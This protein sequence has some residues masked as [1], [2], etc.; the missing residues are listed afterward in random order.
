M[1]IANKDASSTETDLRAA[2]TPVIE[3]TE[4]C[5]Y[6]ASG[7]QQVR[8]VEQASTSLKRGEYVA[9]TGPSGSGKSTLMNVLGCLD[10]A[11]SGHYRIDGREVSQLS[12]DQRAYIRNHKIGFIF[13]SFNLLPRMTALQN[14]A[15]PL[16]YQMIKKPQRREMAS[17]ALKR[18]GLGDRLDHR[19]NALSGGQRQRVAIARALVTRP[20][21]L[22]ADEPTGNLDSR[23]GGEI[24]ALFDELHDSGQTIIM[25]THDAAVAAR[26]QRILRITDGRLHEVQPAD[27]KKAN[28]SS[29]A[30]NSSSQEH[31]NVKSAVNGHQAQTPDWQV[32]HG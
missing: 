18:V 24:L 30:F 20:Q 31:C 9:L 7:E 6:Y 2:S 21:I 14:V 3:L 25:V 10:T 27:N 8:A 26:C 19:P 12:E 16:I 32:C 4:L 13:Q 29:T 28:T 11:T 22:L 15:Q 5:K 1:S 17:Q 23:T